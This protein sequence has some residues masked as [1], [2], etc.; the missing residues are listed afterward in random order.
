MAREAPS[1]PS[2]SSTYVHSA[3]KQTSYNYLLIEDVTSHAYLDLLHQGEPLLTVKSGMDLRPC[4]YIM[5]GE[6]GSTDVVPLATVKGGLN[7]GRQI[8]SANRH[9]FALLGNRCINSPDRAWDTT[10]P[11]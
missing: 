7:A 6:G 5:R 1:R 10:A 3:S 9:T 4:C 11:I 8:I 2:Q